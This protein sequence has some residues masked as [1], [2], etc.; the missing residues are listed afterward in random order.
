MLLLSNRSYV[1]RCKLVLWFWY[2]KHKITIKQFYEWAKENGV[3]DREIAVRY[4][5]DSKYKHYY[6]YG[7]ETSDCF[8]TDDF[9]EMGDGYV[10]IDCTGGILEE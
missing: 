8:A 5:Y 10:V 9:H 3:E 4:C 1:C 2:G 6:S 7:L